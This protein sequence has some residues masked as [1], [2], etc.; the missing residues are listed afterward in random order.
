MIIK[1]ET[2]IYNYHPYPPIHLHPLKKWPLH[3]KGYSVDYILYGYLKIT[4]LQYI[5]SLKFKMVSAQRNPGCL[6]FTKRFRKI[7]LQSKWN[8]TFLVVPVENFRE[9]RNTRK[10]SPVFSVRSI[11]NRN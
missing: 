10:D 1:K 5:Y 7:R 8:M 4:S 3:Y 9:Q 6:P 2:N 11:P